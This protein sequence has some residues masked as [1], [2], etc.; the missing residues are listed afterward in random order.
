MRQFALGTVYAV[1]SGANPTPIPFGLLKSAEANIKQAK[2]VTRGN[3]KAPVDVGDGDQDITIK[4]AYGEF[5]ASALAMVTAGAT[6][7]TGSKLASI[8]E[9]WTVPTTPF[10]VTVA[11]SATFSEDAGVLDVTAGKWLTRVASAPA[12]GQYSVAA[13]VYTFAAAD[14]GHVVGITY[15]YTSASVGQTTTFM[16]QVQGPSTGYMTR[17]YNVFTIGGVLK[18]VGFEFPLVHWSSLTLALK[19]GDWAEMNMEGLAS[20]DAT[21]LVFKEYVGD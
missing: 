17:L 1:P 13:G 21:G 9:R 10:Q 12:T 4:A 16:N 2:V 5:R 20:E 6:T 8:A 15:G 7:A 11:Q 14:T 19:T 18:P 3:K